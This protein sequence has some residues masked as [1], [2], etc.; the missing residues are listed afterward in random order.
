MATASAANASQVL[1]TSFSRVPAPTSP[2]QIVRWPSASNSGATRA[3]ASSGPD[4]KIVSWPCSAGSLLP[5][6]GASRSITSGRSTPTMAATR[7]IP[8]TPIVLIWTQIAPGARAASIPWSRAIEMTASASVTIVTHDRGSPR[9]VGGGLGDLRAE[10]GQVPGRL[11]LA[12]PDDRR[13]ASAQSTGRHPVA[14]SSDAEHR[15]RLVRPCHRSPPCRVIAKR[16]ALPA[17]RRPGLQALRTPGG[18]VQPTC[19]AV[20]EEPRSTADI[21]RPRSVRGPRDSTRDIAAGVRT[22]ETHA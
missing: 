18:P 5:D 3:R 6:T 19:P 8:A 15:N 2:T 22:T 21:R 17:S 4:A 12:V 20:T 9:R 13:D 11:H 1:F 14:H 16:R 10:L 7:S